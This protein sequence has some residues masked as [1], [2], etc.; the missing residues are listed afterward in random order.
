MINKKQKAQEEQMKFGRTRPQ[1][2]VAPVVLPRAGEEVRESKNC[3]RIAAQKYC[4]RKSRRLVFKRGA[5]FFLLRQER[6]L[7]VAAPRRM[8]ASSVSQKCGA[9]YSVYSV[10][11]GSE[12]WSRGI[13]ELGCLV[14]TSWTPKSFIYKRR[15]NSQAGRRGFVENSHE[16]TVSK[17]YQNPISNNDWSC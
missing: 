15:L 11:D 9:H 8:T 4:T 12:V 2:L 1:K 16:I 14:S 7:S 6:L 3:E 13:S 17:P 10:K 5:D